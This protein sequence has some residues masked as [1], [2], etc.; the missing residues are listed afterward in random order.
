LEEATESGIEEGGRREG[1]RIDAKGSGGAFVT[2][3]IE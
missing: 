2:I 3:V 1:E